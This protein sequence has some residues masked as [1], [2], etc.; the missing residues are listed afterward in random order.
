MIRRPP[1]STR[2]D[3]LFPYTTLF[4]SIQNPYNLLNRSYEN[5]LSEFSHL[6]GL[7]LLAYSPLGMGVLAG[8]YLNGARPEGARMTL[9]E[10]FARYMQP[11]A[12]LSTAEYAPLA[13][14]SG[15]SPATIAPDVFKQQP[16]ILSHLMGQTRLSQ[17]TE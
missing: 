15:L 12:E 14:Y 9:F 8:K 1:R 6:E 17:V 4:R 10:R 11:Q 2:T 16:F 5:G 3:T 7:G 13:P